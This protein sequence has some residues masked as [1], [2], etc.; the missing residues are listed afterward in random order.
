LILSHMRKIQKL[1]SL[2]SSFFKTP[3]TVYA[4]S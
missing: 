3:D 4:M 2:V 1:P